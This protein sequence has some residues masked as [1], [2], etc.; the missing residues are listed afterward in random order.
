MVSIKAGCVMV[1]L[2]SLS[3]II[4]IPKKALTSPLSVRSKPAA[5]RE[6]SSL[7][8]ALSDKQMI[9]WLCMCFAEA[10]EIS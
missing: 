5:L 10:G 8:M 6:L 7:S 3:L 9:R 2:L 1:I 4:L